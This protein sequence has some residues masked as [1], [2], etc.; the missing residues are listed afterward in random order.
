MILRLTDGTTTVNLTGGPIYRTKYSPMPPALSVV[1]YNPESLA[2]GGQ[3]AAVTRR[4]VEEP[5]V[6]TV[7]D[8]SSD[9]ARATW[10]GIESLFLKAIEYANRKGGAPVYVEYAQETGDDVYRSELL[11]GSGVPAPETLTSLRCGSSLEATLTWKRRYYWEGPEAEVPLANQHGTGTGGIGIYNHADAAHDNFVDVDDGDV[12][13]VLPA[14]VRL[15]MTNSYNVAARLNEVVIGHN[16][17]SDPDTMD[18]ILEAEDAIT[19]A[20]AGTADANCSNGEYKATE[21]ATTTAAVIMAWTLDATLLG[22]CKSRHFRLLMRLRTPSTGTWYVQPKVTFPAGSP[23]TVVAEGKEVTLDNNYYLQDLGVVQLPPWLMGMNAELY[24]VDLSLYGRKSAGTGA[25][26]VDYVHLT[27]LDSYRRLTPRGYGASYPVRVVDDGIG[28]WLW[29]DGW[30][31]NQRTGHYIGLGLPVQLIPGRDQRL[32]F[33]MT[34][35]SGN[36]EVARTMTVRAYY[37][38]RRLTV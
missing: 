32:Y 29:T 17:Y 4:N 36:A 33:L 8:A 24:P 12:V 34:S 23:L 11:Y 19:P 15:E 22:H 27:A 9:A 6:I 21:T 20:G 14:P 2:D 31:G 26:D 13:G 25:L 7:A 18:H 28:G 1:E 16:V 35:N 5:C 3:A 37:R 30:S 38:P 10:N